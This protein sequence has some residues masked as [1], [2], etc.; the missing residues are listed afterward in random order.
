MVQDQHPAHVLKGR[1][2]ARRRETLAA[3]GFLTPWLIGLFVFILGPIVVSLIFS[4]TDYNIVNPEK[5]RFVGLDNYKRALAEDP[6]FWQSLRV[7]FYFSV[8]AIPANLI[9][10]FA[11][12]F[13]LNK[14][15]RGV[16]GFRT[17][18]YLPAVIS[19]VVVTLLWIWILN[20]RL[21]LFNYLLS[22]VGIDGPNW[23]YSTEWVIPSLVLIS[24][25]GIG[26]STLIYLAM[27][28]AIPTQLYEAADIDGAGPFSR[29][30][31][32]TIPMVTPAIFFNLILG[33]IANFQYFTTA[34]V[35]T[36]GGPQ[37]AS[38]FYALYLYQNAFQY[39][40]MGYAS[41]LAWLL[42]IV[43]AALTLVLFK[44]GG[45]W[46]FYQEDKGRT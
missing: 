36:S 15:V 10:G 27:L 42:F 3:F 16:V 43:V 38:L 34:Y 13:L 25:W 26:Q 35:G 44:T 9:V 41:A 7:T 23:L 45:I 8:L 4:L 40:K 24:L 37:N 18:F 29:L 20:P 1:A 2:R 21:G 14:G 17:L 30:W 32:I 22:L 6:L 28:Q 46:V 12:A 33:L 11:L 39:F 19:G 5:T 31:R